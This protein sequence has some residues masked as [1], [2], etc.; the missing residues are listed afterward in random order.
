MSLIQL[1]YVSSAVRFMSDEELAELLRIS[2]EN[3]ARLDI[4]GL[5]LYKD[6][7]FIQALEGPEEAV[8]PLYEKIARDPRHTGV[9][10]LVKERI[11]AR[12]F[13]EWS[14]GFQNVNK[15]DE[16]ELPGFSAFLTESF[17]PENFR[18]NPSRVT[19]LLTT[20]KKMMR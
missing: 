12:L 10:T 15:M 8:M 11:K 1:V 4:T 2:R 16:A 19:V 13:P 6:G 5:L 17:T 14:M 20:F 3:N 7:N 18:Q 9:M